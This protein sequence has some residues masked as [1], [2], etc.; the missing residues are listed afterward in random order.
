MYDV[1]T[2]LQQDTD[3]PSSYDILTFTF[4]HIIYTFFLHNQDTAVQGK[5]NLT[6]CQM[7]NHPTHPVIHVINF[8]QSSPSYFYN[9]E[10][11]SVSIKKSVFGPN[12]TLLWSQNTVHYKKMHHSS[13]LEKYQS[14]YFNIKVH[15]ILTFPEGIWAASKAFSTLLRSSRFWA[16][17]LIILQQSW[18]Q[19]IYIYTYSNCAMLQTW[20]SKSMLL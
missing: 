19:N 16:T 8:N 17:I 1:T 6:C 13:E 11:T 5:Q 14:A 10:E 7:L 15:K 12:I 9:P 18:R 20:Q 4:H 2:D 3:E